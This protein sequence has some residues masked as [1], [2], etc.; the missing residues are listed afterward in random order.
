MRC[1]TLVVALT[2]ALMASGVDG[3]DLFGLFGS[4]KNSAPKRDLKPVSDEKANK[5]LQQFGYMAP[6]HVLEATPNGMSGDFSDVTSLFKRAVRKFQEFAGLKTTGELDVQTK[7]KMA[8]PRCGVFDVQAITS[9]REAAFKW[10]K[11]QLTYSIYLYSPDL[12]RD[13]IRRAIRKAFDTWSAVVPLDFTEV[14]ST[15]SS[16]DIKI[17][18]AANDHGDPWPF[19]GQGGVLAHA[20][21]PTSGLLHFDED[22]TWVYMDPK[23]IAAGDTDLLAVAIHESGHALGL[24]HSRDES[25]IMAPFYKET[26]DSRGNYIM[27]V[28]KQTDIQ[29]IQDIYGRR[30]TPFVGSDDRD[31]GRSS[32]RATTRAMRPSGNDWASWSSWD[33]V[34]TTTTTEKSRS[35]SGGSRSGFSPFGS[36]NGGEWSLFP[37]GGR[38]SGSSFDRPTTTPRTRIPS[39]LGPGTSSGCPYRIDA[40]SDGVSGGKYIFSGGNVHEF[41]NNRITKSHSL[42][43]LFPKGPIYVDAALSNP[44]SRTLMLFQGYNVYAFHFSGNDWTLD[45]DFPKR[46]P[47]DISFRPNGGMLWID[48]HQVLFSEDGRFAIYD[49]YWNQATKVGDTDEYFP[50]FPKAVKGGYSSHGSEVVLFSNSRVYKYDG[51]RKMGIGQPQ[52]ISSFFNC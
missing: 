35:R 42:R 32:G 48:G 34:T 2:V 6:S 4:K 23:R 10:K 15:D 39:E 26:V 1:S 47:R 51:S 44:Q 45:S 38:G 21:M 3:F 13:D 33:S 52:S 49:E 50:D 22:E 31:S 17:K 46:I 20:T 19:D 25:S 14:D 37:S 40:I 36:D 28:L 30:T 29:A 41:S 16:A 5:Y 12:S 24:S 9:S 7:K 18:F 43:L 27:P 11:N 8:E